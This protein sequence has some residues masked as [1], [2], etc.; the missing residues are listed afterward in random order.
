[1]ENEDGYT[2]KDVSKALYLIASAL[3]ETEFQL[4][5]QYKALRCMVDAI[6]KINV[7]ITSLSDR[8]IG[9]IKKAS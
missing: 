9:E 3:K 8:C 5:Q 7:K 2:Y 4:E 6:E 1:M